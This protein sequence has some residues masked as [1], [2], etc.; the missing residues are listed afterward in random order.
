MLFKAHAAPGKTNVK[1]KKMLMLK[2][3]AIDI[4][5]LDPSLGPSYI[6]TGNPKSGGM[7]RNGGLDTASVFIHTSYDIGPVL[8]VG[9]KTIDTDL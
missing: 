9:A 6:H 7:W 5:P 8:S 2:E 3:S 4:D 1:N